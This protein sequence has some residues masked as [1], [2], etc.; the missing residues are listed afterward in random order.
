MHRASGPAARGIRLP[1]M[2]Q[3][4]FSR[5][6]HCLNHAVN[7]VNARQNRPKADI[8]P[9]NERLQGAVSSKLH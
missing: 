5:P 3:D 4:C 9:V 6:D 2:T 1:T 8:L 7:E